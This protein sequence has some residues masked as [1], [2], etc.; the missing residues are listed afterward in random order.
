MKKGLKKL[1]FQAKLK[2]LVVDNLIEH[3]THLTNEKKNTRIFFFCLKIE[4]SMPYF[5]IMNIG[6]NDYRQ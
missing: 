4:L 3:F 6:C 5:S 2:F 1:E